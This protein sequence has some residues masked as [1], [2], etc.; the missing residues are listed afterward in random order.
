MSDSKESKPTYLREVQITFKK[1]RVKNNSPVG[2]PVSHSQ[3]VYDLFKDLQNETKEKLIAISLDTQ[4]KIIS[5]EIVAIGSV[6]SIYTRPFEVI[7]SAIALNADSLIVVHNH[8]SGDVTPSEADKEFTAA[9][10][11]ITDKGGMTFYDHVI[12]G[13]DAYFSFSDARIIR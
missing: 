8:P 13:D 4:A 12:I 1:K 2:K 5:F 11:E 7:R 10:K 3:Q 9:L 6:K